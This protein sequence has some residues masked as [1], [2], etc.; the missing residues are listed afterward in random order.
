MKMTNAQ[1]I[2]SMSNEELAEFLLNVETQ[3]YNG[4]SIADGHSDIKE[5]LEMEVENE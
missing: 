2:R 4:Y 5:W 3:G 1:W